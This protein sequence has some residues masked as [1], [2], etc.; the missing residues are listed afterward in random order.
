MRYVIAVLMVLAIALLM[1]QIER[2]VGFS[3]PL[4]ADAVDAAEPRP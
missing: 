4:R 2:D 1:G 3:P